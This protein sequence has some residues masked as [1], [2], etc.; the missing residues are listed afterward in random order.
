MLCMECLMY[1]PLEWY[2]H[3]LF[4]YLTVISSF[5]LLTDTIWAYVKIFTIFLA[6]WIDEYNKL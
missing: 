3:M 4:W 1:I 2:T 6:K 5:F